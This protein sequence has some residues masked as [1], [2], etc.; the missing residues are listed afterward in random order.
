MLLSDNK[1]TPT[2][3]QSGA[4]WVYDKEF[5]EEAV[6]L[7]YEIG[8][9]A[10]SE[11]LGIPIT[12]LYTW[13]SHIKQHGSIAF[14]GSGHKRIDPKIAEVKALEKKIRELEAANDILNKFA[15]R[16]I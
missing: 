1:T 15:L 4:H 14:V 9:K 12:T 5:K 10:T 16:A 3:L 8:N 7:S 2:I 6:K 13:K 11:Q